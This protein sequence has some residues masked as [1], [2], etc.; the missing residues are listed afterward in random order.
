MLFDVEIQDKP[1][2]DSSFNQCFWQIKKNGG[3]MSELVEAIVG[4]DN[5][6]SM[7]CTLE[8]RAEYV[9][10]KRYIFSLHVHN[11]TNKNTKNNINTNNKNNNNISKNLNK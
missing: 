4:L 11:N 2:K 5:W 1:T 6:K 3:V 8:W 10:K 7:R 9:K